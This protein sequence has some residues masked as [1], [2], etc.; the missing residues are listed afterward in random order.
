MQEANRLE[1]RGVSPERIERRLFDGLRFNA[2]EHELAR[3]TRARTWE[4]LH[5]GTKALL[6]AHIDAVERGEHA[7]KLQ[8]ELTKA[9]ADAFGKNMTRTFLNAAGWPPE[10]ME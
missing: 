6:A 1:A 5:R 4:R 8:H 2:A 3:T 10:E 9:E 7:A